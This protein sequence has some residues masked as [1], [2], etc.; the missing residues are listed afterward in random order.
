MPGLTSAGGIPIE[1]FSVGTLTADGT[2][3]T[4]FE[5]TSLAELEGWIDLANME[6]GDVVIIKVYVKTRSGG[7]Y[8]LYDSASYSGIQSSPGLH[9]TKLPAKYGLKGTVQQTTGTNRTYDF[10]FFKR[11]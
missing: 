5:L 10:N 6:S 7:T 8:R 2:E 4:V 1:E 9:I 11:G 3:Q